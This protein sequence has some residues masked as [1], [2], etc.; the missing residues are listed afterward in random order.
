MG[1]AVSSLACA[2]SRSSSA[3]VRSSTRQPARSTR[4]SAAQTKQAEVA[5]VQAERAVSAA[6]LARGPRRERSPGAGPPGEQNHDR[7]L[8]GGPGD[9]GAPVRPDGAAEPRRPQFRLH[10]R[11]RLD[12]AG[13]DAEGA[14]RLPLSE[15]RLGAR[16]GADEGRAVREREV[17]DDRRDSPGGRDA[18]MAAAARGELPG[19]GRAGDR[20][21]S[22]P[23]DHPLDRAAADRRAARDGGH[24][25]SGLLRATA[26]AAA[27]RRAAR[28]RR[29][30]S[31]RS[32]SRER[33]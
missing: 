3:R 18:P 1:R 16:F 10:A 26:P 2:A 12:Q 15:P 29:S 20:L 21:R 31:A 9:A 22:E 25:R 33:R 23:L 24:P 30:R 5:A 13:R 19:H 11:V 28:G 8:P 7:A 14:L 4:S 27:G 32:R 17:A 6:A